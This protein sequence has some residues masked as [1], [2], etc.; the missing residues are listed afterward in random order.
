VQEGREDINKAKES[1]A[2]SQKAIDAVKK[3]VEQ[4]GDNG[5]S[6]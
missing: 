6:R 1:A 4:M 2:Q 5:S 3:Q